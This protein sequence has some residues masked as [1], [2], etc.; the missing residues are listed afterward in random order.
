MKVDALKLLD[1]QITLHVDEGIQALAPDPDPTFEFIEGMTGEVVFSRMLSK[2][3]AR[4][5]IR[6][7]VRT[8]CV[9]C[10]DAIEL[11][12]KADVMLVYVHDEDL[13]DATKRME[14]PD[15]MVYF[16]GHVI[17]PLADFREALMLE[18]PAYPSCD[19]VP[20]KVCGRTELKSGPLTFGSTDEPESL[21][22]AAEP[23]SP[24]TEPEWKAALRRASSNRRRE[25]SRH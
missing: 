24:K 15:E 25:S 5:R 14:F 4:G 22:G 2:V 8:Q 7:R 20:N 17:E 6:T 18:L 11:P 1:G 13:L 16:D 12:I 19:L 3:L 23:V 21:G 10:L 9:R